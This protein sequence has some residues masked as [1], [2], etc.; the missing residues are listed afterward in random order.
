MSAPDSRSGAKILGTRVD[1]LS[2]AS[3]VDQ[4]LRWTREPVGRVVCAANV[5]MIM[6]AHDSREFQDVVNSADM[7]TSDGVP[8]VWTLRLLG[9]AD[10]ERVYG[11][12]LM[13][14]LCRAAEAS[15]VP[16][17]F[18]GG[19]QLVL[20][21]MVEALRNK[22]PRLNVAYAHSPPFRELSAEEDL[23][24]IDAVRASGVR[25][26]FVGLGCPK[27]ERW[28]AAHKTDFGVVQIGVGAAFA[29]HA[30]TVKQAPKWLQT[31]GLEWL[32]RLAVEPRRLWRR[33]LI[34][35]PRFV[36]LVATELRRRAR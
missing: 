19:T 13:I 11:P 3:A 18:Y 25:L 31:R 24:V 2:Y 10:A 30:G 35:N 21:R 34:H 5:H 27:Q 22:F 14:H 9:L 4:L 20:H 16:V 8:L 15:G 1:V 7:V 17:G 6:E 32:F 36:A 23:D 29:F 26:L 28:M 12:D 33:Y